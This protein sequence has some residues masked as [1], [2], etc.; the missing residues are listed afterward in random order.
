MVVVPRGQVERDEEH[1]VR[2]F[3]GADNLLRRLGA[4]SR[5]DIT[6]RLHEIA[7]PTLVSATRDDILVPYT[8]SVELAAKLAAATLAVSDFGGH[9]SNVTDPEPFNGRL[10]D[11]LTK[12]SF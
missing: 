9:A 2:H 1:A 5:F 4:L 10:L 3:Q 6:E 8:C 7:T 11:F 12:Q